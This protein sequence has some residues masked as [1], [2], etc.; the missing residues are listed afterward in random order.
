MVDEHEDIIVL[1]GG[2][3]LLYS[4]YAVGDRRKYIPPYR[5]PIAYER[6]SWSLSAVGWGGSECLA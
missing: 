1:M 4:L 2:L 6:Q 5:P 3:L